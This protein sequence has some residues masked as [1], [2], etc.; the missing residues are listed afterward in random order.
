MVDADSEGAAGLSAANTRFIETGLSGGGCTL[1]P[2]SKADYS[3]LLLFGSLITGYLYRR[4]R[5]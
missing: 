5:R 4:L 2:D 1:K 3:L